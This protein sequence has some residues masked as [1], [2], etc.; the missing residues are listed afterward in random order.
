[1][2]HLTQESAK[3]LDQLLFQY[4]SVEAL[5]ELAGQACAIAI[6]KT[7]EPQVTA[8]LVG[9][10]NN[11]NDAIV[12]ARYLKLFGFDVSL[13]IPK[14]KDQKLDSLHG[15]D[16]PIIQ[17]ESHF[18]KLKGSTLIVDGLLGFGT[19]GPIKEPYK[20]FV[21]YMATARSCCVSIDIPS[22]WDV[23]LGDVYKTNYNP[24]ML[25]SLTA[26]KECAKYFKGIHFVGGRFISNLISEEYDISIEYNGSELVK[27]LQ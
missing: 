2:K 13:I 15:F 5:I 21:D 14:M 6:Q 10:G 4:F 7:Y 9:S 19:K 12:C 26:P 8:V 3:Q 22:G 18:I 17:Q 16:I 1:M 27:R 20:Q 24:E 25:V 23:A 11:G